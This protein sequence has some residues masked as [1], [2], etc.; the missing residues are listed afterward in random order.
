MLYK[1]F[2]IIV[3]VKFV[4]YIFLSILSK[5][6]LSLS[7]SLSLSLILFVLV[8]AIVVHSSKLQIFHGIKTKIHGLTTPTDIA[9]SLVVYLLV[10]VDDI[11]MIGNNPQFLSSL[12]T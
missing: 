9:Q 11:V 10:Y 2:V 8:S 4:K 3:L 1:Q 12:I 7:L 5:K 6:L